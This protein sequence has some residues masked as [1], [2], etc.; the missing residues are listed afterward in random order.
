MPYKILIADD[1]PDTLDLCS[2]ILKKEGYEVLTVKDGT[3]AAGMIEREP[4][5]LL[6]LDIR[7]PG[8]N[9]MEVLD[10]ATAIGLDT[11]MITAYATIETAVE[12]MKKGAKDYIAK[13]FTAVDVR[14][15][16]DKVLSYQQRPPATKSSPEKEPSGLSDIVGTSPAMQELYRMIERI[17]D[18]D[19]TIL[20]EGESGTGKELIARAIHQKSRRR[21][22]PFIPINCGAIPETLLESELFGYVK[23]AFTGAMESKQGLFEAASKG[24]ILLDE[25]AEMPPSIQVK[26]LRALQNKEV[27]P[28][29]AVEVKKVDTRIIA[30]TNKTLFREASLGNFREDLFYRLS[31]ISLKL[32]PLRKRKE[33]IAPL[34]YHF[35]NKF[36]RLYAREVEGITPQ[37]MQQLLEYSW[38]GNV[39]ELENVIERAVIL[40]KGK[41]ISHRAL[42]LRNMGH[43]DMPSEAIGQYKSLEEMEKEHIETVLKAAKG[44]RTKAAMILGI[45]R[46][47]LYDK[48][49]AYGIKEPDKE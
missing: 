2:K 33:D 32:P 20:I 31:V 36:S 18:T 42:S 9:G 28:V 45:G 30:T 26:F 41:T 22:G 14:S 3:E 27:R 10:I 12:A 44:N 8:K 19:S 4:F 21:E 7:M 6:L 24:T 46:R 13:P 34:V 11:V 38:P 43:R 16:V 47:T 29:G 23:G 48:I 35:I 37:A 40:E 25:I 49:I 15:V 17:A 5:D 39:R 1:E